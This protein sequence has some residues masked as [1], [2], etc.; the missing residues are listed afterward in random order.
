MS[1]DSLNNAEN[2]SENIPSQKNALEAWDFNLAFDL[3]WKKVNEWVVFTWDCCKVWLEVAAK[4]QDFS[5]WVCNI[6]D[7][8]LSSQIA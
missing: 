6:L 4:D 8:Y 1:V 5:I 7:Q 3:L 2:F